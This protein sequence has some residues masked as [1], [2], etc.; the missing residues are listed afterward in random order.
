MAKIRK[1]FVAN[2]SSSSFIIM[3]VGGQSILEDGNTDMECCGGT[4]VDID[5]LI[6]KLVEAK[7]KGIKRVDFEH[8][9][10]YDG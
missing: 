5:A 7:A 9:G 3:S 1:S 2:S 4:S 6:E 8:G 10:G